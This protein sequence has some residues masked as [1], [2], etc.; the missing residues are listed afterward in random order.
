MTEHFL[1][2][3]AALQ[4]FTKCILLNMHPVHWVGKRPSFTKQETEKRQA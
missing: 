1:C 4:A 3:G 2:E